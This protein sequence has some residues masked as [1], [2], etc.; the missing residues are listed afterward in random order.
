MWTSSALLKLLIWL[1][2]HYHHSFDL[3]HNKIQNWI[4]SQ[5]TSSLFIDVIE[6]FL[7]SASKFPISISC[8]N[9]LLS[10]WMNEWMN[11]FFSFVSNVNM[12]NSSSFPQQI[13][14][15]VEK[16]INLSRKSCFFK[17]QWNKK[18]TMLSFLVQIF[19]WI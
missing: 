16:E 17:K 15:L 9:Q 1:A 10:K 8:L 11:R 7:D 5:R 2:K 6:F 14:D 13:F 3:I 18:K 12:V 4:K 19:N